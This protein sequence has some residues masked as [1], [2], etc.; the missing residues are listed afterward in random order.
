MSTASY[1]SLDLNLRLLA[2]ACEAD[3]DKVEKTSQVPRV[4]RTE[5]GELYNSILIDPDEEQTVFIPFAF[6]IQVDGAIASIPGKVQFLGEE[7]RCSLY[8]RMP[9]SWTRRPKI[10]LCVPYLPHPG[11]PK[12]R[13]GLRDPDTRSGKRFRGLEYE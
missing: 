6:N 13:G 11:Y 9:E 2:L 8:C 12:K 10:R 7:R 1:G 4:V 5:E 3:I